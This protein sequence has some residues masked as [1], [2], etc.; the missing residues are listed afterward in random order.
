MSMLNSYYMGI[1]ESCDC[2]S[3]SSQSICSND[4]SSSVTP[5]G[6]SYR[7]MIEEVVWKTGAILDKDSFERVA[8]YIE[9]R[10]DL[11]GNRNCWGEY[12]NDNVARTIEWR[13]KVGLIYPSD[14]G[15]AS[16][17]GTDIKSDSIGTTNWLNS[18][19]N[20]WTLSPS[21]ISNHG[22]L[23]WF[24]YNAGFATGTYSYSGI[25]VRPTIY[26]KSN[27]YIVSGD[28]SSSLPYQISMN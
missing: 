2:C 27:V 6:S 5:I 20:Y 3:D 10:G 12:C 18:G 25:G 21:A 24:V 8:T 22:Y 1:S 7:C 15:Y 28:G 13:G 4:C 16:T 26:L 17:S 9:E 11:K 14:Y 19:S 23:A